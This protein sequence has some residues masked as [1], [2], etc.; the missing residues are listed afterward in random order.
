MIKSRIQWFCAIKP[1]AMSLDKEMLNRCHLAQSLSQALFSP[2]TR[3]IDTLIRNS[4][5]QTNKAIKYYQP[6]NERVVDRN[7]PQYCNFLQGSISCASNLWKQVRYE[8][9]LKCVYSEREHDLNFMHDCGYVIVWKYAEH[10]PISARQAY[11]TF[12]FDSC[13]S[14][15]NA[16]HANAVIMII[17]PRNPK[18]PYIM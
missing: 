2:V 3:T 6:R 14:E 12:F 1:S 17:K 8:Q 13:S 15:Q 4:M 11:D 10:I 18:T 5:F 9:D 16:I 7:V